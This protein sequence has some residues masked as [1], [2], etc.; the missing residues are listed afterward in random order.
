MASSK[1]VEILDTANAPYSHANV[2]LDDVLDDARHRSSSTD[3][4]NS[5]S[6]EKSPIRDRSQ[7]TTS[8]TTPSTTS[9]AKS[10]LRGFSLIKGKS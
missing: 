2:S 8:S 4:T 9:N 5:P 6:S 10:R 7:T 3:S 1:F